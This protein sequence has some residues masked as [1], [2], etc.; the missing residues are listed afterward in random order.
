M[1]ITKDLAVG[2]PAHSRSTRKRI[3]IASNVRLVREG[4]SRSLRGRD[5]LVVLGAVDLKS[6]HSA[7]SHHQQPDV[8]VIDTH[9]LDIVAVA[10][11]M[12][13]AWPGA[14]LVA[15]AVAELDTDVLACAEAGF[16]GFVLR[17]GGA[18]ELYRA[19]VDAANGR[20]RCAPQITAAMFGRLAEF[21]QNRAAAALP[22]VLTAREGEIIALSN[23]GCSNK[24]VARR[25][26]ISDATVKNH[27]HNIFQKL[28][29]NGR[30]EAAAVMRTE[31][32]K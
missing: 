27:M 30:G 16:S 2:V 13:L 25:L 21:A 7:F 14:I 22:S 18:N 3:L 19:I 5:D 26:R 17:E 29:V 28:G 20:V 32:G 4:L 23:K 1:R 12:R 15:F 24:E 11:G 31:G 6:K 8:V 9:G 10:A